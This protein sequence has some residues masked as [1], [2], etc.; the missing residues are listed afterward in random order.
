[1]AA[2]KPIIVQDSPKGDSPK[3]TYTL[4]GGDVSEN[5]AGMQKN[6]ELHPHGY[7]YDQMCEVYHKLTA[8]GVACEMYALHP[9][10]DGPDPVEEAWLLVIRK[11]VQHVLQTADTVAL[12]A[13]NDALDMDKHALIRRRSCM[14]AWSISM[15]VGIC[16]LTMRTRSLIMNRGRDALWHGSIFLWCQ[17]FVT[18]SLR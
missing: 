9:H 16:A 14:G 6:G 15:R 5:H 8:E 17:R 18:G 2:R 12:M 3:K 13:E 10:Y 1:M 7:S 11:G 4:T